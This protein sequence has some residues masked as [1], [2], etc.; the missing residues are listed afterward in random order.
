MK[1][2]VK[3]MSSEF[4]LFRDIRKSVNLAVSRLVYF[5]LVQ[6]ILEHGII[7]WGSSAQF[8]KVCISKIVKLLNKPGLKIF[9]LLIFIYEENFEINSN[10]HCHLMV[11]HSDF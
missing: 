11:I 9:D 8:E 1:V 7:F 2:I 3:K 4:F 10:V 6:F 5:G